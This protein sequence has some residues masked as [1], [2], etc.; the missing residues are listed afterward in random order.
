MK[1]VFQTTTALQTF[2]AESSGEELHL[3]FEKTIFLFDQSAKSI[4]F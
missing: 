1:E 4:F 2:S 3:W